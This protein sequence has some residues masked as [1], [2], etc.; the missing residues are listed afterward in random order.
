LDAYES[1]SERGYSYDASGKFHLWSFAES[2]P[3]LLKTVDTAGW[4]DITGRW[5]IVQEKQRVSL[6]STDAWPG[7]RA[8]T[9]RRSG[10]W[11]MA[12]MG[13]HH[14]GDWHLVSTRRQSRLSF[15]PI[16]RAFPNVLDAA[17]MDWMP[18]AFSRDGRW[19]AT[20]WDGRLSFLPLPG[21]GLREIRRLD[22]PEPAWS[23]DMVFA[24]DDRFLFS[25]NFGGRPFVASLDGSAPQMLE[26]PSPNRNTFG[27]AVSPSGR[28]I[29]TATFYGDGPERL[30]VWN[31]ETGERQRFD[32]PRAGRDEAGG[33]DRSPWAGS[34]GRV[35]TLHFADET[36]LY[37]G[38]MGGVRRWNLETGTHE[39]VFA[40]ESG[41]MVWLEVSADAQTARSPYSMNRRTSNAGAASA[42]LIWPRGR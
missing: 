1:D 25:S 6:W 19:L 12:T 24:P 38:G 36:T 39:L 3:K 37:T 33:G 7:A 16:R 2:L 11:L 9:L 29:A 17:V 15:W 31:L 42:S 23:S 41:F 40:T 14:E 20:A 26:D 35:C 27:A 13:F 22:L 28:R 21:T 10:S 18:L 30:A 32:L 8:L 4:L 5:E 34:P